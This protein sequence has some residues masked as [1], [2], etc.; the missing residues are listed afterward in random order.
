MYS[1]ARSLG[2]DDI[3]SIK[4]NRPAQGAELVAQGVFAHLQVLEQIAEFMARADFDGGALAAEGL[5]ELYADRY[6]DWLSADSRC[7]LV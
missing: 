1:P 7:S 6:T 3:F 4:Q 5:G 2:V